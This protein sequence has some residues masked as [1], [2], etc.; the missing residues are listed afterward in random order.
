MRETLGATGIEL[1]VLTWRCHTCGDY[2]RHDIARI[3]RL[4]KG[5]AASDQA[6]VGCLRLLS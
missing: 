6:Q 5:F 1:H 2:S 3:D 4:L